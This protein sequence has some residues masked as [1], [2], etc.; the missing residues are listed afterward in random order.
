M[1]GDR[2]GGASEGHGT[3]TRQILPPR[4]AGVSGPSGLKA[5]PPEADKSGERPPPS[6]G[7]RIPVADDATRLFTK[8]IREEPEVIL[9]IL[10]E[11][12]GSLVGAEVE[13]TPIHEDPAQLEETLGD[14]D[15]YFFPI[16]DHQENR[17]TA[18]LI[19]DLPAAVH[20]GA[21]FAL[22]GPEQVQEVLETGEVPD[23]LND[24]IGEV[25][26]VICGAAANVIREKSGQAPE[27]R[28]AA[29]FKKVH[30][31]PWPSILGDIN[32]DVP[33]EFVAGRLSLKG[34]DRGVILFAGSDEEK[35]VITPE[36]IQEARA[37]AASGEGG[38][39]AA[40]EG[41]AVSAPAAGSAPADEGEAATGGTATG[42]TVD[43]GDAVGPGKTAGTGADA[44]EAVGG[45][46]AAA[47]SA[48]DGGEV[49]APGKSAG[50]TT[51]AGAAVGATG[52]V[53]LDPSACR[54]SL[55]AQPADP[56]AL[57]LRNAL[58]EIGVNV[59]P[60]YRPG[61]AVPR[62]S[63]AVIVVTR[64]PTDLRLRAERIRAIGQT[65]GA[66][67]VASD[68]PTRQLV[69][70][71]REVGAAAFLV[72]PTTPDKLRELLARLPK[73]AAPEPEP[74]TAPA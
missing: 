29:D 40:G 2:D 49:A 53:G 13:I 39:G 43:G 45:T 36:M 51:A 11:N 72:L 27:F 23:I 35:G 41:E 8:L 10:A 19:M 20:A 65:E 54:I 73:P 1:P 17:T 32:G 70:A 74:E 31:G 21:A 37:K 63:D 68:H 7:G 18:L 69:L 6:R 9:Q 38:G 34:E 42:G 55:S 30:A 14:T 26:N 50:G 4:P 56:A 48:A 44:G 3:G 46:P 52:E 5:P 33:W 25:A 67:V 60:L 71:A 64:S 62:K 28:R 15:L 12:V 61:G 59:P 58:L 47:G 16:T 57:A 22:M 66:I 24:S